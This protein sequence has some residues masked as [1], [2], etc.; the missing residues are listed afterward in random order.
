MT[1]MPNVT[2]DAQFL[3]DLLHELAQFIVP[4]NVE[5]VNLLIAPKI[6]LFRSNGQPFCLFCNTRRLRHLVIVIFGWSHDR[7]FTFRIAGK[8]CKTLK[9]LWVIN[10]REQKNHL[11]GP[12]PTN[13]TDINFPK[14][15]IH[16]VMISNSPNDNNK[17]KSNNRYL[18]LDRFNL[19]DVQL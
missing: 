10:V 4:C 6:T 14:L 16:L 5:N 18:I 7:I 1:T 2:D 19:E 3:G 12:L 11:S 17:S 15:K 9:C 13:F 8:N